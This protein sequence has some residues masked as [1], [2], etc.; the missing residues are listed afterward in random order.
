MGPGDKRLLDRGPVESEG[1]SLSTVAWGSVGAKGGQGVQRAEGVSQPPWGSRW[2][3]HHLLASLIC[4]WPCGDGG[5]RAEAL[6]PLCKPHAL[7]MSLWS[8]QWLCS[9]PARP[10][11]PQPALSSDHGLLWARCPGPPVLM[12]RSFIE[13]TFVTNCWSCL[14]PSLPT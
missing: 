12:S 13:A 14:P 11:T 5:H 6:R 1:E 2:A 10:R 7:L 4:P 3:M 8:P 9:Q